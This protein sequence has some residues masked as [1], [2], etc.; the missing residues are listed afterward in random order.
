MPVTSLKILSPSDP[1]CFAFSLYHSPQN[2]NG[3]CFG[4]LPASN[5]T[6]KKF[7]MYLTA[8][9]CTLYFAASQLKRGERLAYLGLP[10]SKIS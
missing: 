4:A 9:N 10:S 8:Y 3:D 1:N 7:F 2:Q 5:A 6:K